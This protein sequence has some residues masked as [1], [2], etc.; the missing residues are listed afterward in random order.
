MIEARVW[1]LMLDFGALP[2]ILVI[3]LA[4]AGSARWLTPKDRL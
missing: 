2:L 4:I 3:G 1:E